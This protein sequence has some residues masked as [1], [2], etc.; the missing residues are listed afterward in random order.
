[1]EAAGTVA[2]WGAPV[3]VDDGSAAGVLVG[4]D[5]DVAVG[6]V[7]DGEDPKLIK[8]SDAKNTPAKTILRIML[9]T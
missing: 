1:M 9:I 4:A 7:V 6:V 2:V 5:E 8:L 3:E